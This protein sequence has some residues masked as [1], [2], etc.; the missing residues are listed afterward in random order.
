[1]SRLRHFT[2]CL[3]LAA[4]WLAR[5]AVAERKLFG[6]FWSP[7]QAPPV[8]S[9]TA[10]VPRWFRKEFQVGQ[11]KLPN[12][13]TQQ[14]ALGDLLV[15]GN[16][17][18]GIGDPATAGNPVWGGQSAFHSGNA[19]GQASVL[20]IRAGTG[21]NTG[22]RRERTDRGPS[23]DLETGQPRCRN[24]NRRWLR[25]IPGVADDRRQS[26]LHTT[27]RTHMTHE[28]HH[29]SQSLQFLPALCIRQV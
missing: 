29:E 18:S 9:A 2:R 23:L 12:A 6:N 22:D 28:A 11:H 10:I 17:Q 13:Q 27:A 24:G 5:L 1:M 25:A 8:H 20:R 16:W 15:R 26:Q 19:H 7:K 14:L 4:R 3:S 21:S